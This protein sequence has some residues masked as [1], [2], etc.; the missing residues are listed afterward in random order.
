MKLRDLGGISLVHPFWNE[1]KRFQLQLE[2]WEKWSDNTKNL[3][4]ITIIDDHAIPSVKSYL[5]PKREKLL[6]S[7]NMD[8]CIYRILDDLKWNTP[9]ALNLGVTV[10]PKPW[11]LFMDSDCWLDEENMQ[12]VLDH[13]PKK[14]F[15]YKF[16][17]WRIDSEKEYEYRPLT[18]TMLMHKRRFWRIRFD[19]DFTGERSGGY[20]FFDNRFD[21]MGGKK[22]REVVPGIYVTEVMHDIVGRVDRDHNQ[23]HRINRKIMYAKDSGEMPQNKQILNFAWELDYE[24]DRK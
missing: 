22:R 16:V 7:L 5:G 23:H 9:G 11:V 1:E 21:H 10:A 2:N 13:E 14:R 20:G 17:R 15:V 18:C 6:K 8:F 3:V 4:D 12:K 19:E 24:L